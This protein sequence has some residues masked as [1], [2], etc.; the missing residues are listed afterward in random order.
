MM[1]SHINI[2]PTQVH[3]KAAVT[4]TASVIGAIISHYGGGSQLIQD[5]AGVV[6]IVSG[7]MASAYWYVSILEKLRNR[8]K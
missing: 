6:A 4:T 3:H 2:D 7:C 5:V 1:M 8:R